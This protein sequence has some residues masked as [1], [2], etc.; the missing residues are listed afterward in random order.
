MEPFLSIALLVVVGARAY[1]A[2]RGRRLDEPK[3]IRIEW[4]FLALTLGMNAWP[5]PPWAVAEFSLS[6]LLLHIPGPIVAAWFTH[7]PAEMAICPSGVTAGL[8]DA[9]QLRVTV[10]HSFVSPL[11][12]DLR[13]T[14]VRRRCSRREH[15]PVDREC[16]RVSGHRAGLPSSDQARHPGRRDCHGSDRPWRR[17]QSGA[18]TRKIKK[19]ASRIREA[20]LEPVGDTGI[21]PVTSSV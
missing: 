17:P 16:W 9:T 2:T 6:R 12:A 18:V 11:S 13:V 15:R 19:A 8:L 14:V 4:L 20:A 1:P 5:Y 7:R 21:E 10:G 3:L